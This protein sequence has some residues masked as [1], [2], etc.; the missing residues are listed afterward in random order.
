MS[1][2]SGLRLIEWGGDVHVPH[3]DLVRAEEVAKQTRD[4]GL[5]VAAYGSYYRVGV[6]EQDGL[7]FSSVLETAKTLGAP[8]I[9]VWPGNRGSDKADP[10]FRS[11]V[12]DE[13]RRIAT[14]A[15]EVGIVVGT[16][17]H[18]G[19]LTDTD[20][21]ARALLDE[22][23][24]PHCRTLWQPPNGQTFKASLQG[25]QALRGRI[26]HLHI[27]HWWPTAANRHALADG[28]DRWI[29]Y[30]RETLEAHPDRDIPVLM[31]FVRHDSVEQFKQD[32]ATL[33]RWIKELEK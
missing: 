18:S 4:A 5:S 17:Y 32:A 19:T 1:V 20:A 22:V 31:E 29:P 25:L 12:V 26:S 9:R 21:S 10:A 11:W 6:S 24:H 16:E 27:F 15:A 2:K 28:E 7:S 3:G 30:L 14:M 13:L 8:V 23:N 33:I